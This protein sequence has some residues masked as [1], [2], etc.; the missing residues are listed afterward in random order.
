MPSGRQSV[1]RDIKICSC[2]SV[3]LSVILKGEVCKTNS[4]YSP[5]GIILQ[6]C[7][8]IT[9]PVDISMRLSD[10]KNDN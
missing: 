2:L 10:G 5:L 1:G 6:L 7:Q 3:G 8:R 9:D 4:S